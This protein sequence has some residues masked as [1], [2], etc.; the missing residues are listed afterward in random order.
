MQFLISRRILLQ[1]SALACGLLLMSCTAE[2]TGGGTAT[3]GGPWENKTVYSRVGMRAEL[4]KLGD[5]L[6]AYSTNHI[7]LPK[8]FAPGTKFTA[9]KVSVSGLELDG[10]DGSILH[11]EFVARHHPGMSFDAWMQR[12]FSTA[13]VELPGS[14][15]DKELAA[16]KE[17]RY[18]VGMSRAA[19]FLSIGYP[20]ATMSPTLTDPILKY[21]IKRFNNIVFHFDGQDRISEIK[22]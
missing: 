1:L 16:I 7:G 9:R 12:Q 5:S 10:E 8:H 3:G 15:N 11:L 6:H 18:E 21:E 17:G 22:D 19:L 20:P 14:L 2:A 13:P 4:T